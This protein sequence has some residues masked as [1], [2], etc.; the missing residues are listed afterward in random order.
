MQNT[1]KANPMGKRK[2]GIFNTRNLVKLGILAALAGALQALEFK[3]PFFPPW[4]SLDFSDLPALLGSFAMGPVAGIV[5]EGIKNLLKIVLVGTNTGGVGELA[6]F[7]VGCALCVPAAL[8]YRRKKTKR[9]ALL[10]MAVGTVSFCVVGALL[11]IF[12]IMPVYMNAFGGD[13]VIAMATAVNPAW[14][15]VNAIVVLGVT[16]FNLMKALIVSLMTLLLYK[17]LSPLLHK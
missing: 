12:L 8:I 4:L 5:I 13:A 11:N 10:G 17:P 15:N 16:P 6:N 9:S 14:A 7:L 3:I 2:N 1:A